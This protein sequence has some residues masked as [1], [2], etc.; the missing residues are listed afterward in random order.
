MAFSHEMGLIALQR[1]RKKVNTPQLKNHKTTT[2][3][4]PRLSKLSFAPKIA[5]GCDV[6]SSLTLLL[7]PHIPWGF[8]VSLALTIL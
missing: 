5:R 8:W 6:Y 7:F 1:K 3:L 2:I 4:C